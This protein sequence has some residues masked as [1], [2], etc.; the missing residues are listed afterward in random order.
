MR[1]P[2]DGVL[3]QVACPAVEDGPTSTTATAHEGDGAAAALSADVERRQLGRLGS[4]TDCGS[5]VDG[6][7]P[8]GWLPVVDPGAGTGADTG[9]VEVGRLACWVDD[10]GDSVLAWTWDD[11]GTYSVAEQRGGGEDG[12]RALLSWWGSNGDR[13]YS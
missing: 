8:S 3:R 1:E 5:T 13:G 9:E 2:A 11:L 7:G 4:R 6:P 10:D 12:L